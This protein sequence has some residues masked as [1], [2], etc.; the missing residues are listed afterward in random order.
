MWMYILL[1]NRENQ[2]TH[3]QPCFEHFTITLYFLSNAIGAWSQESGSP[4]L[5][6]KNPPKCVY[7]CS[8]N[9][10]YFNFKPTVDNPIPELYL[11]YE[12]KNS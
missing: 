10:T 5:Q 3:Y 1:E 6:L 4:A 9:F 12:R 2:K 7:V 11:G 8:L